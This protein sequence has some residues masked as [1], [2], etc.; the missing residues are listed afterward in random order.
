MPVNAAMRSVELSLKNDSRLFIDPGGVEGRK[1]LI[2]V[3]KMGG[4]L[5]KPNEHEAEVITGIKVNSKD[6]AKLACDSL[7]KL[8]YEICLLT[9]GEK[10]AYL[11]YQDKFIH[12]PIP[13]IDVSMGSSVSCGD[14][15]MAGFI[16]GLEIGLGIEMASKLAIKAGT[17]QHTKQGIIPITKNELT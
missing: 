12:L 9:H 8:G 15:T 14:Q 6:D 10:G 4:Y 5:I 11:S 1:E 17:L 13:D 16:Y 2:D 7:R 3:V